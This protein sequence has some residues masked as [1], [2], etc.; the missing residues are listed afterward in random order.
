[1]G[2]RNTDALFLRIIREWKIQVV[3]VMRDSVSD[4][5]GTRLCSN[6]PVKMPSRSLEKRNQNQIF[7]KEREDPERKCRMLFF[8]FRGEGC[9]NN[10]VCL[11]FEDGKGIV[12][13][14]E[15]ERIR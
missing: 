15:E 7:F 13:E 5:R 4:Y 2:N 10:A 11:R 8:L 6:R 14:E 12:G 9:G 3:A 1:M